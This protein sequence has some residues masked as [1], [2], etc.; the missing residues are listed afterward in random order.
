MLKKLI[1]LVLPLAIFANWN[2]VAMSCF[3]VMAASK[4][5]D[6]EI[7]KQSLIDLITKTGSA[8][9]LS[10]KEDSDQFELKLPSKFVRIAQN[11]K[12]PNSIQNLQKI[13]SLATSKLIKAVVP[14]SNELKQ[15]V[16]NMSS[17]DASSIMANIKLLSPYLRQ[18]SASNIKDILVPIAYDI[19]TDDQFNA[20][21]KALMK[22][23]KEKVDLYE[24]FTSGL[25]DEI[26][27][28]IEILNSFNNEFVK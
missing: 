25:V 11:S 10:A 21:Y 19:T 14:I 24:Y 26:F 18:S 5:K 28:T 13:R 9:T 15:T 8:I 20:A 6:T 23:S 12:D 17:T 3:N 27:S 22:G 16:L 1:F 2:D 7:Y 4:G